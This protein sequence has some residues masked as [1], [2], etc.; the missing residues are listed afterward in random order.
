MIRPFDPT[1]D[2][3]G[4]LQELIFASQKYQHM[5]LEHQD[6]TEDQLRELWAGAVDAHLMDKKITYLVDVNGS[7]NGFARVQRNR[8]KN[9]II[10]DDLYVKADKRQQGIG[11]GL[12]DAARELGRKLHADKLE[13]TLH[14]SNEASRLLYI[15]NGFK[16]IEPEYIDMAIPL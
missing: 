9:I 13:I 15:K 2:D 14:Q 16:Q 6:V 10:I 7:I 1:I 5:D 3:S 4:E 12:V 8:K 11:S